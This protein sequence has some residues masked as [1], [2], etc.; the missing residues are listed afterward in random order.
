MKND[1][2]VISAGHA[3]QGAIWDGA[4]ETCAACCQALQPARRLEVTWGDDAIEISDH[5]TVLAIGRPPSKRS[6]GP[7]QS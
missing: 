2:A 5:Y 4:G 3:R 6:Q 1:L 7:A